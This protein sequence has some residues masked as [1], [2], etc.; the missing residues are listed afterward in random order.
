[1]LDRLRIEL[2]RQ[3]TCMKSGTILGLDRTCEHPHWNMIRGKPVRKD[4]FSCWR[5]P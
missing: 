4:R 1:M 2:R 3:Q 5:Q